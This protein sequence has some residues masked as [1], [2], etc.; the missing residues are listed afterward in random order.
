MGS[1]QGHPAW[2]QGRI[3]SVQVIMFM[4]WIACLQVMAPNRKIYAL[5]RIRLTGRD[6]EA[7]TGFINEIKLLQSLRGY[8]NIIQLID[9]EVLP[10]GAPCINHLNATFSR[11][12]E[13][14]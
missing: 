8:S 10:A 5:K 2:G 7:A 14:P 4:P 1:E 13:A 6:H 3:H 12:T 11:R 9:A